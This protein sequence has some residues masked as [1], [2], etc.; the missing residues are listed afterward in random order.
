MKPIATIILTLLACW[1]AS[2]AD[3]RQTFRKTAAV[4]LGVIV[5]LWL[6]RGAGLWPFK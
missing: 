1:V 3:T 2:N 4:T 5:T 6:W